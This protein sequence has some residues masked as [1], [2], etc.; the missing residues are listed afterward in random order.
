MSKTYVELREYLNQVPVIETHS[1]YFMST[2]TQPVDVFELAISSY[3]K[4]DLQTVSREAVADVEQII[5]DKEKPFDQRFKCFEK[6]Y[7]A[8]MH[9]AYNKSVLR[10]LAECWGIQSFDKEALLEL[11]ERIGK[12]DNDFYNRMLEKY[13]LKIK[14]IDP[15]DPNLIARFA[16]SG[17]KLKG[18]SPDCRFA[19]SLPGYHWWNQGNI[20]KMLARQTGMKIENLDDLIRAFEQHL[21]KCIDAG[22]VCVKDQCAYSRILRFDITDRS[23]ADQLFARLQNGDALSEDESLALS[24]WLMRQYMELARKYNIP[25]QIHTGHMAGLYNEISKTNAV[26]LTS[27]IADY[28]DVQFDLFHGNWPYM[29]EYLFLGKNYPNVSLDLC[30]V[31]QIDPE[32]SIELIKRAIMTVPHNKLLAFGGDDSMIE[33]VIGYLCIARDNVAAA[34]SA[35]V[36]KG[37]LSLAHARAI[38]CDM[39][40][41]NPNKVFKLGFDEVYI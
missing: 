28:S 33:H 32:Y 14:I 3:S 39:F 10:G 6:Y 4:S 24:N 5:M 40:F 27:L 21:K 29:G 38:C 31:Q 35:L 16:D 34:L 30:W 23:L 20:A 12:R 11:S 13:K 22:I 18:Y 19:F 17:G 9:T 41:N 15:C 26:H 36:D 2:D 8:S 1:H 37:W 7:A 25:V